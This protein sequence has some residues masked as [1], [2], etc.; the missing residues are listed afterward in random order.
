MENSALKPATMSVSNSI[1]IA[2]SD[3]VMRLLQRQG[4]CD[5]IFF[6]KRLNDPS[7]INCFQWKFY[8]TMC[9]KWLKRIIEKKDDSFSRK[10]FQKLVNI[11][12][13]FKKIKNMFRS[14]L[15]KI[16]VTLKKNLD[17][18]K[19]FSKSWHSFYFENILYGSFIFLVEKL[20]A[21]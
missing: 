15:A 21:R 9:Y 13:I 14:I 1:E 4:K 5:S 18:L 2:N 12:G 19:Y 8:S 6:A 17:F 11:S 7:I 10:I 20:I 16:I 3:Q